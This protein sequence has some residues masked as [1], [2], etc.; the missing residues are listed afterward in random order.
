MKIK[1]SKGVIYDAKW[2]GGPTEILHE[3][4]CEI[5]DPRQIG[6][7]AEEFEGAELTEMKRDGTE[8]PYTGYTELSSIGRV[9]GGT[10][11]RISMRKPREEA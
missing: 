7:I 10:L 11:T 3:V 6:V 5:D 8:K 4:H 9:D 2:I 1:S